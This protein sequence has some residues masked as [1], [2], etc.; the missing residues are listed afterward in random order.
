MP[1]KKLLGGN[2]KVRVAV[3]Q[4]APV[5]MDKAR[6]IDKV[7][8]LLQ[9]AGSHGAQLVVFPETFI[10]AYPAWYTGGWESPPKEWS[11]YMLALQD[12][13]VVVGSQDTEVLGQACR[14]AGV[15][16]AIGI[17]ELDN[18]PGSRTI[19]N[20]L[21]FLGRDG[22][23]LGRHRKLM[24]TYTERTYWGWG[25]ASDLFVLDTDIGRIG[26]LI[27]GENMMVLMKAA[28][29]SQGEE[30]HIAVWPGAWSG[31][32]QATLMDPETDPQGGTC[33]I[34][35]L[36]RSYA[37]EA[38][39]FVLSAGSLLRPQDFPEKW[40]HLVSSHH[41]NC[42]AAVG[43]SAMVN[44]FGRFMAGPNFGQETLLYAD[45]QASQIKLAKVLFDLLG[46]YSRW[47]IVRLQ[48]RQEPWGPLVKSGHAFAMEVPQDELKRISQ[49]HQV[50]LEKL[51][52]IVSELHK[53]ASI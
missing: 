1:D 34:Y 2:D 26:G 30:F 47:D 52:E 16:A 23:L 32:S 7:C 20:T 44:P 35:P 6:T 53:A 41:L 45:C 13:A 48:V 15:Y 11:T 24:P 10:P 21:L 18:R 5:F 42:S 39:C 31:H 3:A 12:N 43:G 40:H 49:E 19:Y 4:A 8:H 17:N 14:Q 38:Q 22:R 36:I 37:L 46:H 27:C 33:P 28:M 50:S 29:M 25:D 9:E 51:E